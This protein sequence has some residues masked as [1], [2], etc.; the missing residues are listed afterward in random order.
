MSDEPKPTGCLVAFKLNNSN[1]PPE[2]AMLRSREGNRVYVRAVD[3]C[4]PQTRIVRASPG[5]QITVLKNALAELYVRKLTSA[6]DP[7]DDGVPLYDGDEVAV[8]EHISHMSFHTTMEGSD[9]FLFYL[10]V[11]PAREVPG[12]VFMRTLRYGEHDD[13]RRGHRRPTDAVVFENGE[14]RVHIDHIDAFEG[15]DVSGYVPL[16]PV[17]FTWMSL[18]AEH[19]SDAKRRF[20]VAAARRLDRAHTLF[21]RVSELRSELRLNPP[22]GAPAVRRAVFDLLGTTE[23]AL[24]ALNRAMDMAMKANADI[25]T[26]VTVPADLTTWRTCV[27]EIR[28]AYEHIDERAVGEIRKNPSQSQIALSIFDHERVVADGVIAYGGYQ[29]DLENVVPDLIAATRKCLKDAAAE[30]LTPSSATNAAS[31]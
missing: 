31:N 17:L 27:T 12:T 22:E 21:E 15:S 5:E 9:G 1:Q 29:L 24:V 20:L 16:T 14:P 10:R 11:V 25:G 4:D 28:D 2:R 30:A 26:T 3:P 23:L 18:A 7:L 6:E 13:G 19:H 8:M